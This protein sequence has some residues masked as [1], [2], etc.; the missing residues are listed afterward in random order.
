MEITWT[1]LNLLANQSMMV[2]TSPIGLAAPPALAAMTVLATK[3]R[4]LPWCL[5]IFRPI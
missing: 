3:I 4:K 2:V 5:Y 1:A